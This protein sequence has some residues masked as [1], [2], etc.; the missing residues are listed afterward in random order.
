MFVHRTKCLFREYGLWIV[1][2]LQTTTSVR[3][4]CKRR[5]RRYK[6]S[7][8]IWRDAFTISAYI[9]RQHQGPA[10][11]SPSGVSLILLSSD[12]SVSLDKKKYDLQSAQN[13]L[14]YTVVFSLFFF[15]CLNNAPHKMCI[16][17]PLSSPFFFFSFF[18]FFY[19]KKLDANEDAEY[20]TRCRS[21]I[22][23]STM[24]L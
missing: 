4:I 5:S 10:V 16:H 1:E 3:I 20:L 19:A 22:G 11:D 9:R 6:K 12:I 18:L 21:E 13:I 24:Y 7:F 23:K 2:K 14:Y 17:P 8:Q 15:L